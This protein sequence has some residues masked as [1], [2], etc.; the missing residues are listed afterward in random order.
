MKQK[1][2]GLI[3]LILFCIGSAGMTYNHYYPNEHWEVIALISISFFVVAS[4]IF[5]YLLSSF[6]NYGGAFR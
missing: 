6:P 4:L 5:V 1:Y 2:I 3:V